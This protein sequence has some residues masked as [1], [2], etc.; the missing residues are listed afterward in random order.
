[1]S[2]WPFYIGYLVWLLAG[3]LDFACHRRTDLP[4]TSGLGESVFHLV[5]M[6]LIGALI[7]SWMLSRPSLGLC[8]LMALLVVMHTIAGYLDTRRAWQ[9][10]PIT[11][12]EQHVHSVLDAA[13]WMA[14]VI[15]F[16]QDGANAMAQGWDWG[17]RSPA[18]GASVW[19][20]VLGPAVLLCGVP[21]A[22]ELAM[23]WRAAGERS[24][25]P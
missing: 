24:A 12:V 1:M 9:R 7:V 22:R 13:P 4:H 8:L 18:L 19:I 2:W 5:Q 15:L 20:A 25:R 14:L 10:R 17:W 23:A 3:W 21:L 6:G 16:Y 11:P